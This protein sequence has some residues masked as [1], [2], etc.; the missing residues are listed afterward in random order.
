MSTNSFWISEQF[1]LREVIYI[2]NITFK[3]TDSTLTAVNHGMHVAGVICDVEKAFD[4]VNQA[5]AF[6]GPCALWFGCIQSLVPRLQPVNFDLWTKK[7]EEAKN[8]VI[9]SY[10]TLKQH[11][12]N[13]KIRKAL[14]IL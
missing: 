7:M 10:C 14:Y 4:Y 5:S 13:F 6:H 1:G 8:T 11:V 2:E 9:K 12:I 3:V